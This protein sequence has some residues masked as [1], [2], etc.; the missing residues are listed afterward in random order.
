MT[1]QPGPGVDTQALQNVLSRA[2]LDVDSAIDSAIQQVGGDPEALAAGQEAAA[3][4][5]GNTSC[6][7]NTGC[8]RAQV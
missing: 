5:A 2:K 6:T 8:E 4:R 7:I 1:E 3:A